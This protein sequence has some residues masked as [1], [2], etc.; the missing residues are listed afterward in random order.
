METKNLRNIFFNSIKLKNESY[1][2]RKQ[3]FKNSANIYLNLPLLTINSFETGDSEKDIENLKK[4]IFQN[5][6][7]INN[8][9]K[10]LQFLKIQY[11]KLIKE[12]RTYKKLIYEVLEL[13][14]ETKST[15]ERKDNKENF[16]ESSYIG[17]E[18]LINKINACK[19][20][21]K[22]KKELETSIEMLN[23]KEELN[24]KRKLLLKKKKEYDDLKQGISLKNMN[25]MSTKLETIRFNEKKLKNEVLTME[26]RLAKN[27]EIILQLENEIKNE[28][29]TNEEL[30]KQESE[31]ETKYN[32]KFKEIK[33]IEKDLIDI[34]T[35]RKLKINKITKN[36]KYEGSKLKGIKLRTKID[37]IK[38]DIDNIEAYET[39]KREDLKNLLEQRKAII[40]DLKNKNNE[41]EKQINDLE[42]KNTKLYV[43]VNENKE[44]KSALENRGKEQIKDIKRLKDL[45]KA[46]YE[47]N[48]VK[49][50]LIQEIEKKQKVLD[51]DKNAN[52]KNNNMK[53]VKE[54][55]TKEKH[56][57]EKPKTEN[58]NS[59][60]EFI[61]KNGEKN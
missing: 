32:N 38:N 59:N 51:K 3:N 42:Q 11:N 45:E 33:E 22:Q 40:A 43:K 9:K 36:V 1:T 41:L 56:E 24:S 31:Y 39:R 57:K 27:E 55:E 19:I 6:V 18:Q 29:K 35:R 10:E 25:E 46:I 48:N 15:I 14:D 53:E 12:N 30:S 13:H 2:Y 20:D 21:S 7:N 58:L 50:K 26:E 17:E 28:E 23:L 52:N 4:Q 8:K 61:D 54:D 47:L 5:K 34:D 37:K 49:N 44:E 16:L 60:L